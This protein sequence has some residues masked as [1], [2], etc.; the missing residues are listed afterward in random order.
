MPAAQTTTPISPSQIDGRVFVT[1]KFP[2]TSPYHLGKQRETGTGLKP[3]KD[4]EE[5]EIKLILPCD[6]AKRRLD[7]ID[8]AAHFGIVDKNLRRGFGR[9]TLVLEIQGV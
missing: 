1:E 8:L 2:T 3:P 6:K 4:S 7:E 5:S 9:R